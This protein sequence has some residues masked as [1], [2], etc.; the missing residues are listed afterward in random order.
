MAVYLV[1]LLSNVLSDL[2]LV[3]QSSNLYI[4]F[5]D[6]LVVFELLQ[7]DSFGGA[8]RLASY[9]SKARDFLFPYPTLAPVYCSPGREVLLGRTINFPVSISLILLYLHFYYYSVL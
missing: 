1:W 8:V 2:V 7:L 4:V 6:D 5:S 9:S 3:I